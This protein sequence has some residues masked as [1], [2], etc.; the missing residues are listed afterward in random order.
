MSSKRLNN[1]ISSPLYSRADSTV[2]TYLSFRGCYIFAFAH[3][4]YCVAAKV[5]VGGYKAC[6]VSKLHGFTAVLKMGWLYGFP[7]EACQ[8][9]IHAGHISQKHYCECHNNVIGC[10]ATILLHYPRLTVGFILP[11][12]LTYGTTHF[13]VLKK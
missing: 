2:N 8:S 10:V 9:G 7:K 6:D 1:A 11:K 4:A 12:N 3:I 5:E 13:C